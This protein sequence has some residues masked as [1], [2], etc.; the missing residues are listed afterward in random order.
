M[1]IYNS[2]VTLDSLLS[3]VIPTYQSTIRRSQVNR[4]L[5]IPRQ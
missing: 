2:F 3:G 1:A 5:Q 4:L